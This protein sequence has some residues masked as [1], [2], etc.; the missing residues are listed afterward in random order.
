MGS[1]Y[2]AQ[3]GLKLLASTLGLQV[4]A[5]TSGSL[6]KIV[7]MEYLSTK[8]A[9]ARLVLNL[10]AQAILLPL[11]PKVLRL[12]VGATASGL[13]MKSHSVAQAG[14]QWWY[15][16]GSLQPCLPGSKTGFHHIGQTG[17]EFLTSSDLPASASQSARITG[18]LTLLPRLEYSGVVMAHC[19]LELLGSSNPPIS[20]LHIAGTIGAY[21]HNQL[22]F[23]FF[24]EMGF[25]HV[26]QAGLKLLGPRILQPLFPKELRLQE[27]SHS[28]VRLECSGAILGHCSLC[29]PG[30]ETGFHHVGK[31]GF[32]P[33]TSGDPPALASQSAEI[34]GMSHRAWSPG[35]WSILDFR[36]SARCSLILLP[37]LECSGTITVHGNLHLQVSS[38]SPALGS[39]TAGIIGTHHHTQ[40]ILVF[41]VGTGFHHIGQAGLELLA[42]TDQPALA[43][44]SAGIT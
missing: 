8:K 40:L 28:V 25:C 36:C 22:I 44:Q 43:S 12:Q 35:I 4:C 33:L 7:E 5:T 2:I 34:T 42:S 41:L 17:L 11:P 18:G 26:S 29:L 10:W 1:C 6:K 15:D 9:V 27:K 13:Q 32:E 19:S 30:S 14:V 20:A 21:H 23:L 16:L 24:V 39:R 31:A 3:A 38:D 37:R